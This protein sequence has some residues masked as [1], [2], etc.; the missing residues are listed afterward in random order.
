MRCWDFFYDDG[1]RIL[2]CCWCCWG[3]SVCYVFSLFCDGSGSCSFVWVVV[4]WK[5]V[6]DFV[7][8]LVRFFWGDGVTS[9][10]DIVEL[11]WEDNFLF[12]DMARCWTWRGNNITLW[13]TR[14]HSIS[15]LEL[16]AEM[17]F[18]NSSYFEFGTF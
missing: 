17:N 14:S 15:T 9:E 16:R 1:D 13:R 4:C 5:N 10:E 3:E 11:C 8:F 7:D 2:F 12:F 18:T 6:C